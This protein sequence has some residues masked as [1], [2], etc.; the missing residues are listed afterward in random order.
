MEMT[1]RGAAQAVLPQVLITI[2]AVNKVTKANAV[3]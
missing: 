3:V 1:M 2:G